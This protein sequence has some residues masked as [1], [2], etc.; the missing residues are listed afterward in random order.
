MHVIC[1]DTAWHVSDLKDN[2]VTMKFSLLVLASS[3]SGSGS[4]TDT[5]GH[6]VRAETFNHNISAANN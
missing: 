3:G 2:T 4:E 1:H 5:G 6:A